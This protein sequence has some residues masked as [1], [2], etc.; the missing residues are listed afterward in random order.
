MP[1]SRDTLW[2]QG[3]V[4]LRKDFLAVGLSDPSDADL[5][6]A[7]SHDCDIA[8]DDLDAEPAVEF[9]LARV[10]EKEDGNCTFGKNPRK[11]HLKYEHEGKPVVLELVASRRVVVA[12]ANLEAIQPDEAYA[13]TSSRQVLQSW[14]AI[15]YRRHALP[16][17]LVERLRSVSSYIEKECKKNSEGILSFR[18]SYDPTDE[19]PPEEPYELWLSIVYTTDKAEYQ[20]M[21]EKVADSLKEKF[22]EL[23]DKTKEWGKI[24]LRGC[25]AVS[26]MEFTMQDMRQTEEYCLEHL[27]NRTDPLGP[28]V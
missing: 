18:L 13:L 26:E 9:I 15:R 12:K 5:A 19:L 11:L 8:N 7:I 10:V 24:E 22:S 4:L 21:A 1:W 2:R 14:L 25:K 3:R 28:V 16:N 20:S 27:S 17:S 6:I 23:I